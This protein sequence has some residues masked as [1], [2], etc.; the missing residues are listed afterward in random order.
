MVRVR[1]SVTGSGSYLNENFVTFY[2]L[3]CHLVPECSLNDVTGHADQWERCLSGLIITIV[4]SPAQTQGRINHSS[5]CSM[6]WGP[7]L[8]EGPPNR[9]IF[10]HK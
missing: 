4:I 2:Y 6:A 8:S 5:N 1:V 7:P 10:L 3:C 9:L